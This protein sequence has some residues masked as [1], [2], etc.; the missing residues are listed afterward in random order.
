VV[1]PFELLQ[2]PKSN[3]GTTTTPNKPNGWKPGAVVQGFTSA[4][5]DV[6][7]GFTKPFQK[8]PTTSGAPS[9]QPASDTPAAA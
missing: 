2:L 3:N 9:N 5:K 8:K 4:V 6:I 7:N 1:N